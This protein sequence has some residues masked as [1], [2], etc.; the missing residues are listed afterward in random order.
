M[1]LL[2]SVLK[3]YQ[4]P[5]RLRCNPDRGERS[6]LWS[7]WQGL[8]RGVPSRWMVIFCLHHRL[9][10]AVYILLSTRHVCIWLHVNHRSTSPS[11]HINH[12][13]LHHTATN[14]LLYVNSWHTPTS[15][16]VNHW[17][18]YPAMCQ[19][20]IHIH[21]TIHLT[22]ARSLHRRHKCLSVCVKYWQFV[23]PC[24]SQ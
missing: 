11:L 24:E 12:R 22:G 21:L 9:S 1:E 14:T 10:L 20:Q 7:W 17:Q 4:L 8:P 15:L 18:I 16:C 3:Q 2:N 5:Q 6:D 23:H 19:S 13:R